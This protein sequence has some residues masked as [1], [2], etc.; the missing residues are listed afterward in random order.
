MFV[1][2]ARLCS[3]RLYV[4]DRKRGTKMDNFGALKFGTVGFFR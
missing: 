3:E 1:F 2:R 4:F